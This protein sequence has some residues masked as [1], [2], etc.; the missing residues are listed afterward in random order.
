MA[1]MMVQIKKPP[2]IHSLVC[3]GPTFTLVQLNTVVK[4]LTLLFHIQEVSG[5]NLGPETG[6]LDQD[7][8]GFPQS[9]QAN[10]RIEP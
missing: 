9:L 4:W 5:S 10:A 2:I 7:F 6:H 3:M 8:H 1:A